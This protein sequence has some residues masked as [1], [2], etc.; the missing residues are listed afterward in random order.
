[1]LESK[2]E[3]SKEVADSRGSGGILFIEK[4]ECVFVDA[5][6]VVPSSQSQTKLVDIC[7]SGVASFHTDLNR[8]THARVEDAEHM[9]KRILVIAVVEHG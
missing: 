8:S 9:A 7:S 5:N 4:V 1:M 6:N 2:R 3:D